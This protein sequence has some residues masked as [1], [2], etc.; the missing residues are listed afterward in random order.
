MS[1]CREKH[2]D[3]RENTSQIHIHHMASLVFQ[4]ISLIGQFIGSPA[5]SWQRKCPPQKLQLKKGAGHIECR[6]SKTWL[7]YS[8]SVVLFCRKCKTG[9]GLFWVRWKHAVFFANFSASIFSLEVSRRFETHRWIKEPKF[10][11]KTG[12][13]NK[14]ETKRNKSNTKSE[15]WKLAWFGA[16]TTVA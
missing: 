10:N 6:V 5:R 12:K 1:S 8:P 14:N 13:H 3:M 4:R 15:L 9:S 2:H 16:R 7:L 11:V